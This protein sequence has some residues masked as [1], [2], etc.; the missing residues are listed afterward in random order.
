VKTEAEQEQWLK[1]LLDTF[2]A[3]GVDTERD[4]G[5]G[6]RIRVMGTI[7]G[8]EVEEIVLLDGIERGRSRHMRDKPKA[9]PTKILALPS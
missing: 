2:A 5:P 3:E 4:V 9:N 1:A 7:N 6:K 8:D